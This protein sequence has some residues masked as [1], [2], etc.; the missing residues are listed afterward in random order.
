MARPI[1]EEEKAYAAQLLAKARTAMKE[2]EDYDQARVDRLCQAIGWGL[3]NEKTFARLARLGVEESGLGDPESRPGKRFK[4]MG[5]L[6]DVLRQKSMGIIEEIPEKGLVKYAKPAGVLISLIPT[7]NPELTPP[8]VGIFA[9]K[10]KDAV[11]FSPH[12]RS[13]K[14]TFATVRI[15]REILKKEGVPPD[16]YQCVEQPSIPLTHELM[17]IGDL[18]HATGGSAMVKAAYSSGKPAYGV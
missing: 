1:T 12:P 13:K 4:I 6:R 7:T 9:I 16:V 5:I 18:V 2:I 8:G 10:C 11:I 3:A 14:T 17:A 15:M